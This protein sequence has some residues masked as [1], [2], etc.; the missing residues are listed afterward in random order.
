VNPLVSAVIP[1]HNRPQLICRAVRSALNQTYSN[2]EVVVVIDGPD[3]A[4]VEILEALH[5]PRLRVIAL[6]E[7]VGGSEARNIGARVAQGEWVALLDDDDEWLPEK[8]ERQLAIANALQDKNAFV[9]SR[10]IDRSWGA[11]R[12]SP[13]RMP[14]PHERIDEYFCCPKGYRSGE[15]SLLTSTL[16]VHRELMLRIPFVL[17]LKRGQEFSWMI[18]ACAVGHATYHVAPEV[19]S[20][21][22][23]EGNT[24]SRVSTKPKW[25][26]F[27]EWMQA[28]KTC[29]TPRAY[30][31]CIATSVLPDAIKCNEPYTV[32]LKLLWECFRDGYPTPKCIFKF[33]YALLFP[34]SVRSLL[35]A[36]LRPPVKSSHPTKPYR[37]HS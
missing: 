7:N 19:L 15:G 28:N 17:G 8:I 33:I 9:S 29:F 31:F 23:S 30:S 27:Y 3:A 35:A 25:R 11:D 36:K 32:K 4:T 10:Y 20:V 5:E 12:I 34:L 2:L 6:H 22:N 13:L 37:G 24:L 21:F 1:T 14:D 16:L 18:K 26:S